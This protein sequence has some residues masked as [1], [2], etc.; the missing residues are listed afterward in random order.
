MRR[1]MIWQVGAEKVKEYGGMGEGSKA[2]TGHSQVEEWL[3]AV[4]AK[5]GA[6]CPTHGVHRVF[7]ETE[8]V[9]TQTFPVQPFR[10]VS[11]AIASS[12]ARRVPS[13]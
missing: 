5:S 1:L 9:A 2:G 7:G 10:H 13:V 12:G 8:V 11:V 3:K 6:P 4:R